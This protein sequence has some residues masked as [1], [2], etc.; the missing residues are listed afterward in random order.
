M[1]D[2]GN[3]LKQ[4]GTNWG[5]VFR[6]FAFSGLAVALFISVARSDNYNREWTTNL[7]PV[8]LL[9]AGWLLLYLVVMMIITRNRPQ[10]G[11]YE[12]GVQVTHK[13]ETK[14]WLW[15]QLTH[16]DGTRHYQ[17]INLI[18][19]AAWGANTV[20]AG[21]EPA[22]KIS[23]LTARSSELADVVS[24]KMVEQRLPEYIQQMKD[25]QNWNFGSLNVSRDGLQTRKEM[26]PWND[27]QQIEMKDW[28]Q[29]GHAMRFKIRRESKRGAQEIAKL[30]G[31]AGYALSGILDHF[32]LGDTFTRLQ[33]RAL[34]SGWLPRGTRGKLNAFFNLLMVVGLGA[35]TIAVDMPTME[36][37]VIAQTGGPQYRALLGENN[38]LCSDPDRNS[39]ARLSSEV[40]YAVVDAEGHYIRTDL[41]SAIPEAQRAM[42]GGEAPVL[43]LCVREDFVRVERCPY[44][45]SNIER[46]DI[47]RFRTDYEISIVVADTGDELDR[48]NIRG[49]TPTNCPDEAQRDHA[50][51]Y[52]A[53]PTVEDF[54]EW[55]KDFAPNR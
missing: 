8:M 11:V 6:Y 2:L 38:T 42:E 14:E 47:E 21:N 12:R 10:I 22:F 15:K 13:G 45:V 18:P 34:E 35:L 40:V 37:F 26:I 27:V 19:V 36:R 53:A 50:D 5:E 3:K 39:R 28:F 17:R 25:G 1:Y 32:R 16:M 9:L 46:F 49:E 41:Q 55:F 24:L 33:E 51:I 29:P 43:V 54:V 48:D 23:V 7:P 31:S 30:E 44:E 4:Y 52:G 20:Y